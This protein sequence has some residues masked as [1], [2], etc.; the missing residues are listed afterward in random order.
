MRCVHETIVAVE[1]QKVLHIF[2][3]VCVCVG[4]GGVVGGCAWACACMRVAL[5][6]QHAT[7]RHILICGLSSFTIFSTLSHTRHDFQKTGYCA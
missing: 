2:V 6:I 3:C 4:G 5:L 1:E 7:H